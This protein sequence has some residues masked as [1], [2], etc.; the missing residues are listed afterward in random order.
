MMEIDDRDGGANLL[1]AT[2]NG[3]KESLGEALASKRTEEYTAK[4]KA[5]LTDAA[6]HLIDLRRL[7]R[8]FYLAEDR[9][10]AETDEAKAPLDK[11]SL[12][13]NNLLY[14]RD[15]FLREIRTCRNFKTKFPGIELQAE[16]VF[17]ES[18][19]EEQKGDAKLKEDPHQLQL[20][21]LRLELAQVRCFCRLV[22]WLLK[23]NW[24]MHLIRF[25]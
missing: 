20:A 1:S 7:C 18:A 2:V 4:V 21:R 15:H 24:I 16:E 17:W 13:L 14:E 11:A 19:S 22:N 25:T 9:V 12:E 3:L 6:I 10:K 23:A 5:A 8:K